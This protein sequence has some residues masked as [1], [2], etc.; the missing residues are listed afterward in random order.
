MEEHRKFVEGLELHGTLNWPAIGKMV[1]TRTTEQVRSHAQKFF[2]RPAGVREAERQR[3]LSRVNSGGS[4]ASSELV[5]DEDDDV[6]D[7]SESEPEENEGEEVGASSSESDEGVS[8]NGKRARAA[9]ASDS[10]DAAGVA[11]DSADS[12]VVVSA[13]SS[14]PPHVPIRP[15]TTM[16]TDETSSVENGAAAATVTGADLQS[17]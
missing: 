17:Q 6:L 9:A 13:S 1:G 8:G 3:L 4:G 12:S 14:V 2:K 5:G 7:E 11:A 16:S 10:G 15:T